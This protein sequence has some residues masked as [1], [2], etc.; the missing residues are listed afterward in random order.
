MAPAPSFLAK[1]LSKFHRPGRKADNNENV[2]GDVESLFEIES[3]STRPPPFSRPNLPPNF[4]DNPPSGALPGPRGLNEYPLSSVDNLPV[5]FQQ[6][7]SLFLSLH[8]S[9]ALTTL[10][11]LIGKFHCR[12]CLGVVL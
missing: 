1:A 10:W 2:D 4:V 11:I 8:S 7:V 12:V 3:Q 9:L 6:Q 5:C